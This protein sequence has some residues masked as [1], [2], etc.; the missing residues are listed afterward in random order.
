M[1]VVTAAEIDAALSYPALIDIV[2]AAF[3]D[4]VIAPPRHH[5]K[6][7]L[8]DGAP[9]ATLLLMPAWTASAPGAD[10]AGR[11]L[12]VK[13]VSVIPGNRSRDLPAVQGAYLLL[14]AETGLP[15][16]TLDA[17]KLTAWRTAAASALA[18]R[19]LARPNASRMLIVGAG[20]LCPYLVRAYASE[21][22][23]REIAIWNRTREK[24]VRLAAAI[25]AQGLNACVVDDLEAA[26]RQ[27]E[28]IATATLA[29]EP[30]IHGEWLSPGTHLDCVG[31]FRP[32]MRETDDEVV[33]RARIWLDTM[34]GGIAEAGDIVIPMQAGVIARD[35]VEGDL[36][37]LVRGTSK[38]RASSD[39]ITMFKSVGASIED[40]AAAVAI[41]EG[42]GR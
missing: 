12:G 17:P 14:S 4:G 10:T 15:L 5:H 16:A 19:Y 13:A 7:K 6:I 30:L 24:A 25:S 8:P 3:R 27:A 42:L 2:A 34:A 31:A 35:K 33:R 40:L 9:E 22:P 39:E 36:F 20:A 21:R 37:D 18:A 1:R 11:Y 26:S 38:G 41:Y 29:T 28:I 32:H 23:L